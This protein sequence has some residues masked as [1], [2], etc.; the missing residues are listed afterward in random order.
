MPAGQDAKVPA[1]SASWVARR[2]RLSSQTTKSTGEWTSS[3]R[4][5]EK[6]ATFGRACRFATDIAPIL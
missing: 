1:A 5:A 3:R 2:S 6:S 4:R